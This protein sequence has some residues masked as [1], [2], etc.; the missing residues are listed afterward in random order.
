MVV[1]FSISLKAI[2]VTVSVGNRNFFK[3]FVNIISIET[4]P[5]T[6]IILATA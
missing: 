6:T 3:Y 5:R 4:A 2:E 1:P